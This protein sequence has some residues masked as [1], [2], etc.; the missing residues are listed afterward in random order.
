MQTIAITTPSEYSKP[1]LMRPAITGNQP[2]ITGGGM[3]LQ[4]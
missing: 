3:L 2:W 4:D 1:D